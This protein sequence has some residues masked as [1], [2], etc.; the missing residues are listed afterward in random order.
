[1]QP[2]SYSTV[3]NILNARFNARDSRVSSSILVEG[4]PTVAG[5]GFTM[6]TFSTT[7]HARIDCAAI[8]S[9]LATRGFQA[10]GRFVEGFVMVMARDALQ[11]EGSDLEVAA[12]YTYGS[13]KSENNGTGLGSSLQVERIQGRL[14]VEPE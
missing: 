13:R 3:I 10:D 1:V 11:N 12:V 8:A 9:A 7:S 4:F 2:G 6:Q 5:P 14:E